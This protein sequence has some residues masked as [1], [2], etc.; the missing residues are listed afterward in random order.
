VCAR[1]CSQLMVVY[2]RG[3]ETWLIFYFDVLSSNLSGSFQLL[4]R[5][6]SWLSFYIISCI[7][8]MLLSFFSLSDHPNFLSLS[9]VKLWEV[10]A[11][12]PSSHCQGLKSTQIAGKFYIY[13]SE[14][15][16]MAIPPQMPNGPDARRIH[17]WNVKP[18]QWTINGMCI[19]KV[20]DII[21]FLLDYTCSEI[22]I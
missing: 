11:T 13:K 7:S 19:I 1:G 10:Q 18:A 16:T 2:I 12:S 15:I 9:V 22:F 6:V 3:I 21:Y 20:F 8:Q 14:N 5:F 17:M 4:I